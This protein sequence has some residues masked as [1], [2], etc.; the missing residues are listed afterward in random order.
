MPV[1]QSLDR[2]EHIQR[3]YGS[4]GGA[5]HR[6]ELKEWGQESLVVV[7]GPIRVSSPT[8]GIAEVREV[9]RVALP[10]LVEELQ[11]PSGPAGREAKG[12]LFQTSFAFDPYVSRPPFTFFQAIGKPRSPS[13]QRPKQ[14]E[15]LLLRAAGP[16]VKVVRETKAP[17]GS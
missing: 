12:K 16:P 4:P 7:P 15:Q 13:S 5:V 2:H 8:G 11:E 17:D 6:Q 9:G 1:P 14:N 10:E 3:E